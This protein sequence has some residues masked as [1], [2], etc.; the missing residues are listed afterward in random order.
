MAR[1]A[2]Y[3]HG[4]GR[5]H[6]VRS[7][8]VLARLDAEGHRIDLFGAGS[9][10]ALLSDRPGFQEVRGTEPGPGLLPAVAARLP[11]D[12][13]R[14]RRLGPDVVVS[15]SDLSS[16]HA[17]WALRIPSIA[18]GHGLV[19]G[20]CELPPWLPR[21]GVLRETINSGSSSWP[22]WRKVV[23]H[24]ADAPVRTRSAVLARP[25]LR[26]GLAPSS[27]DDGTVLTYFRDDNGDAVLRALLARGER[28]V[29]F[30]GGPVPQGVEKREPSA[31]G[32]ADAL[33]RAKAVVAS[34]G[35][36]LPAECAMVGK[37][38]LGLYRRGDVEQQMNA[39]LL[40]EAGLGLASALDAVDGPLLDRFFAATLPRPGAADRLRRMPSA[41]EVVAR[42]VAEAPT[43]RVS[44][45]AR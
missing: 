37:P 16:V 30:T 45:R 9:S 22:S 6:A 39:A 8:A 3:V 11:E 27:D 17:A 7:R 25:D 42:L 1:I 40:E 44:R 23:V 33:T 18:V 2:Y 29:C 36:H 34:A 15:D 24:F 4:R 43:R 5:G 10:V 19:F 20:H 26:D 38:L 32:F 31:E 41:S 21:W 12:V 35:N 13:A 14:L 28:V